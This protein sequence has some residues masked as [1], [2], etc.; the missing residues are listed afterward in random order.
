MS[1]NVA[2]FAQVKCAGFMVLALIVMLIWSWT[3]LH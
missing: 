3:L 1:E 2:G